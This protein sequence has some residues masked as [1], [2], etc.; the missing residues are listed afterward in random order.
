MTPVV[1][2]LL[3]VHNG[4]RYL[5]EAVE[6]VL[7]Q[8]FR[9]FE[10]LILDDGSTD[11]SLRIAESCAARDRRVHVHT[12]AASG[13]A[14]TLNSGLELAQ[15]RYIARMDAD[16]VCLPQRLAIQTAFLDARPAIGL[17]GSYMLAFSDAGEQRWSYPASDAALR[18]AMLFSNPFA[19]PTVMLRK[20]VLDQHA[21]RY[22]TRFV[23]AQDYALWA[24]LAEHCQLA[25]LPQPLVRYR[26]HAAQVTRSDA[27]TQMLGART[28]REMQLTQLGAAPTE[29]EL[30]LHHQISEVRPSP[31]AGWLQQAEDWMQ[32][33]QRINRTRGRLDPDA[34]SNTIAYFWLQACYASVRYGLPVWKRYM[35]SPLSRRGLRGWLRQAHL[36]QKCIREAAHAHSAG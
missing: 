16:D 28:V 22:D 6:S 33:L 25:N 14:A 7:D 21:L 13:L 3:P 9:D 4:E 19:H 27:E 24:A 20:A 8:T 31:D 1:S 10:L 23:R 26:M 11:D 29:D 15:G 30:R 12:H 35:R 18:C 17:C 5:G 36:L 2:V 34:L 32:T